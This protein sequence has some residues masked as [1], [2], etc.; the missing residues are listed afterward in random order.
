MA[1]V[2]ARAKVKGKHFE[3]EV[4]LDE[5]LKV[6]SGKGDITKALEFPRIFTDMKKGNVAKESDL[7]ECFGTKEPYEIAKK[8]II[9]GEIQKTQEFR[10]SE[11]DAKIKR[12]IDILLKNAVD[13][14][15]RPY[16]EERIKRAVEEAHYS[17]D[18]RAPEQQLNDVVSKL[19]TIIPIKIETKRIKLTIPAQYTGQIYGLLKD[20]K[21]SE[22]WLANGSLQAVLN[23]PAGMQLDFYDKLNSI[24]HG[25]VQSED[26]PEKK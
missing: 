20:Y 26:L 17:F 22:E 7:V 11:K 24:T 15:G 2:T 16:T 6:K 21:E 1:K 12:V 10:D 23:I 13:Q 3:I 18:S 8:I 4:D 19:Q 5:A 9:S 14:N 25:A